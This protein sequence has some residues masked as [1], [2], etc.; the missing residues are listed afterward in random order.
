MLLVSPSER[1]LRLFNAPLRAEG[2]QAENQPGSGFTADSASALLA[3]RIPLMRLLLEGVLHPCRPI[4]QAALHALDFSLD[5][6]GCAAGDQ[7]PA[8]LATLLAA[9]PLAPWASQ[10]HEGRSA[11]QQLPT[12]G[13]GWAVAGGS[14]G[15]AR[16]FMVTQKVCMDF[17]RYFLLMISATAVPSHRFAFGVC[18]WLCLCLCLY[19]CLCLF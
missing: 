1:L 6:V 19:L 12:T 18:L 9:F 17:Q 10:L 7:F 3:L 13:S 15:S 5:V 11:P 14:L 2:Q 4:Q 16:D 8:V